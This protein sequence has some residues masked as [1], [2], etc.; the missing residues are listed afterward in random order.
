MVDEDNRVV[1][2]SP[3]TRMQNL[4]GPGESLFIATVM[5]SKSLK[6]TYQMGKRGISQKDLTREELEKEEFE[7]LKSFRAM[8]RQKME[9]NEQKTHKEKEWDQVSVHTIQMIDSDEMVEETNEHEKK[10]AEKK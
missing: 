2:A 8:R 4:E 5:K 6:P 1:D 10:Q 7:A 9:G 3:I